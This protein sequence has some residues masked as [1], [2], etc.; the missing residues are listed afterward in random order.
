MS[1]R[2]SAKELPA[3]RHVHEPIRTTIEHG[4]GHLKYECDPCFPERGIADAVGPLSSGREIALS[5]PQTLYAGFRSIAPGNRTHAAQGRDGEHRTAEDWKSMGAHK[6]GARLAAHS[7]R[8]T[9]RPQATPGGSRLGFETLKRRIVRGVLPIPPRH[10]EADKLVIQIPTV[11][12]DDLGHRPPVPI[13]VPRF[14]G[15]VSAERQVGGGLLGPIAEVL[16]G[17]WCVDAVKADLDRTV[18][19]GQNG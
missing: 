13:D 9:R 5:T 19:G 4:V 6:G 11:R 2:Q 8:I 16:G 7:H 1:R 17:L 10:P 15:D 14:D 12:Q 3:A 18:I